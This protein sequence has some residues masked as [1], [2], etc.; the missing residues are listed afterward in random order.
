MYKSSVKCISI[1]FFILASMSNANAENDYGADAYEINVGLSLKTLDLD[2]YDEG[3]LN[4]NGSMT[5]GMYTTYYL[6]LNSP[7]KFFSEDSQLGYYF[8][9]G[10]S[11]FKMGLQNTNISEEDLGTQVEGEYVY[12][13]PVVFY[14]F[15]DS[16]KSKKKD[17][18]LL[19]LGIGVG[20]LQAKGDVIFT[21]TDNQLFDVDVSGVDIAIVI[22]MEYQHNEWFLRIQSSGPDVT[23]GGYDYTI[24]DF[25]MIFGY[26]FGL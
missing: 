19:G 16:I 10:Y 21:E 3:S 13:A 2:V 12:V 15:G 11:S 1:L 9:Y 5:E 6:S 23:K 17:A 25:S 26:S 18:L 24:S 22:I 8:E 7:Y 4:Y 20:Y 14:N